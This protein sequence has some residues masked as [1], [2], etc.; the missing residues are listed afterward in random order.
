MYIYWCA[1]FVK[2]KPYY[3]YYRYESHWV[4]LFKNHWFEFLTDF[5]NFFNFL[6]TLVIVL[7]PLTLANG[8]QLA[9][10]VQMHYLIV[11]S[12]L[13]H[14]RINK[15]SRKTIETNKRW[16]KSEFF[17]YPLLTI[18]SSLIRIFLTIESRFH[19]NLEYSIIFP[20]LDVSK[21]YN[22]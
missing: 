19:H 22:S 6:F 4:V 11:P 2:L 14:F 5:M 16:C 15:S 20:L 7:E 18:I 8:Y 9:L 13:L 21:I 3:Y 12:I 17:V 1:T 10:S